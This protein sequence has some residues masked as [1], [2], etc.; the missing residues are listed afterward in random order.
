MS[1]GWRAI[2]SLNIITQKKMGKIKKLKDA[3]RKYSIGGMF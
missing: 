3:L 1:I 2:G